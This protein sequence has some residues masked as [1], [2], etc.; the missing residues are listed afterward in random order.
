MTRRGF[1]TLG[2]A[3]LAVLPLALGAC[4]GDDDDAG[5][6]GG[7]DVA[8]Q[9]AA[10]MMEDADE[11]G[12]TQEQA[13]CAAGKMVAAIGEDRSRELLDAPDDSEL[14]DLLTAEEQ[15]AFFTAAV[16]CL[17]MRELMVEQFVSSGMTE[18]Q[19]NCLADEIGDERLGELAAA[20]AAGEAIDNSQFTDAVIACG[21]ADT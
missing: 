4:G 8:A 9:V 18:E 11:S 19:A 21:V 6:S 16:S 7:G 15:E 3:A 1:R 2:V 10:R 14:E 20:S 13:D 5:G 17:D 12:P